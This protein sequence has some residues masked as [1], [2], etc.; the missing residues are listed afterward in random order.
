MPAI[1]SLTNTLRT[2]IQHAHLHTTRPAFHTPPPKID[3][4]ALLATPT[5]SLDSLLP[6]STPSTS[7]PT[8]SSKQ[9][10]HLLRL[11][12]LPPPE[13]AAEEAKMLSSLSSH[14]HFVNEIRKVHVSGLTPLQSLRDETAAGIEMQ[15]IGMKD[16]EEA[17]K[18]EEVKGTYYTRIRRDHDRVEEGESV[19]TWDVLGAARKKVGRYFVVDGGKE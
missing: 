1:R 14:L 7:T 9:L 2:R 11:S 17:F 19:K 4:E 3:V 8:I 5:W 6:P 10:H 13:D 18:K 15:E 16:L 12:A